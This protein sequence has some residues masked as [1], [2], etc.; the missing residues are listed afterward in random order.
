MAVE[1]DDAQHL[2]IRVPKAMLKKLDARAKYLK[3]K[4]GYNVT[5]SDVARRLIQEGLKT[6]EKKS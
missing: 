6:D 3:G 5:R 1:K 4:L 2:G